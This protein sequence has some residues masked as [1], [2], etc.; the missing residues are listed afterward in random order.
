MLGRYS[1]RRAPL[2]NLVRELLHGARAYDRIAGYFSS[3]ILEVAGEELEA[4]EWSSGQPPCVRIVC[5]SELDP[6]DVETAKAAQWAMWQEWCS[7]LPDLNDATKGRLCRLYEFLRSGRMEVRVLPDAVFGLIHGKAGVVRRADG[8]AIAFLG[9]A[10]ESRTA[11]TLNYE[12]VWVDES[13]EGVDWVQQEFD[14]LWV[15]PA[16]RPL[17]EQVI[18]DVERLS[19]RTTFV[20][21]AE[22]SGQKAPEPAAPIVELPVYRRETGLWAHQKYFVKLAFDAHRKG[23]ARFV[24][25]DQVGLGKTVQLGLVAKLV[26]LCGSQPV[27]A[28]VPRTL[29]E[30]WQDELWGL[31][32]MPS[33]RWNGRQ[34]IDERGVVH[35]DSGPDGLGTCPRRL[36]IV[37]AGLITSNSPVSERLL[38][39]QYDCVIVDEAHRARRSS[40]RS[41]TVAYNNL[42]SF[43]RR[44]SSRTTSLL[45]ATATPVQMDAIEAFDLL[46]ALAQGD[47]RVLGKRFSWWRTRS[48]ESLQMIQDPEQASKT[49]DATWPWFC[50][51]MP[52]EEEGRDFARLRKALRMKPNQAACQPEDL[53]RLNRTD[54]AIARNL[55]RTF[56][57]D[58]NPYIRHIVRRTREFLEK[59]VDPSTSE[60]YLK[61][62]RV[63]LFGE[64]TDDALTLPPYLQDA[65]EAADRFCIELG[66]RPGLNSGFL[67]TILLRRLG[68]SIVA[69][70]RTG[71]KM[72]GAELALLDEEEEDTEET[73]QSTSSLAP[74]SADERALLERFVA[75]LRENKVEDPKYA[76]IERTLLGGADDT[77]PWL[78]VG[79][80]LFSQFY[81]TALWLAQRLAERLPE[82]TLGLYAG[83]GRSAI[84][85]G[86]TFER[87]ER[88]ALKKGVR[89]GE[90]RVLI[91]TDAASEGLNLQRLGSLINVDLPWNPTRLEQRKGRIQRIGQVRDE[92]YI[93]NL[94]YRGSVE[95]RVH[96][97]LANRQH[98]IHALFGQLP[99][100]LEDVWV[101]LARHEIAEAQKRLDLVPKVHP[102]E[103]RYERKPDHV[104]FESCARVLTAETQLDVLLQGW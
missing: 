61:P 31:L 98:T 96:Q 65:Y 80:I 54:H 75:M 27:L 2:A 45:L 32:A 64:N 83:A 38:K 78:D 76:R 48:E 15:H 89:V 67:K 72:L 33:A 63:R 90:I 95:D 30:Q 8:R 59:T 19:R 84:L 43:I 102:F 71:E 58:H 74:F 81:D 62:V 99:D 17:A 44:V 66:K 37:S 91:G 46:D 29:M 97:L 10:N 39:L 28:I 104:D 79:C 34:W 42:M 87:I 103:L 5:N 70:R 11:W 21:V 12:L 18:Q 24:L 26:A 55:A 1:S 51:P 9:S 13:L 53:H 20:S 82:E 100:T 92:I 7:H 68:S 14:A 57:N 47:D 60:P 6:L 52:P 49:L 77:G 40:G 50:N 22:W 35:A 56:F 86:S 23:G 36:G 41:A 25:A 101:H 16:A 3:S 73:A 93:L 85:Q 4:I 88:E 69:G 94:R